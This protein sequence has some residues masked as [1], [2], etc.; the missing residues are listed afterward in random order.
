MEKAMLAVTIKPD[1]YGQAIALLLQMG[2]GFQPRF[3]RTLIVNSEQRRAL[4]VAG[5]VATNGKSSRQPAV[6]SNRKY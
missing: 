2:G 1:K 5:V 3:Q 4:K 6:S